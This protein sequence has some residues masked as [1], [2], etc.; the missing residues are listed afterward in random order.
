MSDTSLL[1]E[2][3]ADPLRR[4]LLIQL[5][6]DDSIDISDGVGS[7]RTAASEDRPGLRDYSAGMPDGGRDPSA[8]DESTDAEL[9]ELHH[10]HLPKLETNDVIEW[11]RDEGEITRGG[12]FETV[13][14][15]IVAIADHADK[16]PTGL[17]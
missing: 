8:R 12:E 14:P 17:R 16:F 9:V 5:C 1:F 11:D 15:G 7:R 3:L 2:L 13:R 4:R 10:V 6:V